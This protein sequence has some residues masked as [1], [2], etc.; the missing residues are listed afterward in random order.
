MKHIN[1]TLLVSIVLHPDNSGVLIVARQNRKGSIDIVNAFQSEEAMAL[2]TKLTT[3]PEK[4][5]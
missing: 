4:T 3:K 5:S 2:Y 1:D